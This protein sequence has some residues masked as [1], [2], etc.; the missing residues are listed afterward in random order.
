M[1][2][3]AK[4]QHPTPMILQPTLT[5]LIFLLKSEVFLYIHTAGHNKNNKTI[6]KK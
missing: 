4:K 5:I 6:K 3:N 1:H 2:R